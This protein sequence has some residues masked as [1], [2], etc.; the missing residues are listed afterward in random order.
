MGVKNLS[1]ILKG[2][3]I[4]I[5]EPIPLPKL[6]N[7]TLGIDG[8]NQLFQFMSSIRDVSGGSMVDSDGRITSHLIGLLTRNCV[9]LQYG[10]EPIYVFDG[11]SHPLKTKE[12]ERRREVTKV[13]EAEYKK[14]LAEGDMIKARS[15]GSR[16]NKLT[17]EML[18][19]S[20]RLLDYLGI[21]WLNA[22]GEGEAQAAQMVIEG[23]VWATASQDYDTML[24]GAPTMVRNLNITGKRNLPGGKV[25]TIQPEKIELFKLLDTLKLTQDQLIDLG[26]LLGT[27]FNPDGF[28]KIGPI[29]G[30]KL[31]Q[32]Y[33]SFEEVKKNKQIV[34]DTEIPYEEIRDIFL[35]P[36][37]NKN[38]TI[39]KSKKFDKDKILEFLV[40]ERSFSRDRYIN[41]IDKTVREMEINKSQTSLDDWF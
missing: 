23:K 30:Y 13:A 33:G 27:D 22:P 8:F 16:V 1:Q 4:D 35:K 26:I 38:L 14:A 10:I 41:I 6:A 11:K 2:Q 31:I 39:D 24:F 7:R 34:K 28:T 18:D 15:F 9:L 19:D 37:V 21:P 29:T 12:K 17:P 36:N 5:K 32:K 3:N 25:I 20:K 40:E